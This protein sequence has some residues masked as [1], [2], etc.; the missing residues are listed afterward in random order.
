MNCLLITSWMVPLLFTLQDKAS[1]AS[2]MNECFYWSKL[3]F[4]KWALAQIWRLGFFIMCMVFPFSWANAVMSM[5]VIS[6][7]SCCDLSG[8]E[9]HR[10]PSVIFSFVPLSTEVSPDSPN[11]LMRFSRDF[12]YFTQVS[13]LVDSFLL[14]FWAFVNLCPIF[15]SHFIPSLFTDLLPINPVSL[16][17]LLQVF[18]TVYFSFILSWDMLLPSN[19]KWTK[20]FH[21][22]G[23]IMHFQHFIWFLLWDL[24][25]IDFFFFLYKI[26]IFIFGYLSSQLF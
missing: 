2:K 20:V 11:I 21:E 12:H 25:F 17:M 19:S 7:F 23:K 3:N 26:Y 8:P 13:Q 4:F 6:C 5:T 16:K 24:Q 9:H 15:A 22:K 10:Q 14:F 1:I 18:N